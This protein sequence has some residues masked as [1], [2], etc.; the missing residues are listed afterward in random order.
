MRYTYTEEE[1]KIAVSSSF[2]IR[3]VLIKLGVVPAGG[4]YY[5]TNKRILELG[6]DTSHFKNQGWSKGVKIGPKKNIECYLCENSKIT[7]HKLKNR[8]L[9][10]KI[11]EHKCMNCGLIIWMDNLIPLELHHVDGNSKNNKI[12]NLQLLCPNCHSLTDN[13]RGKKIKIQQ[14]QDGTYIR[15]GKVY[16]KTIYLCPCGKP[17]RKDSTICK[18]CCNTCRNTKIVWPDKDKLIQMVQTSSYLAVARK[19][20]V[21]DNAVR[22]RILTH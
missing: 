7:T 10:E 21:S 4:N 5:T 11:F 15:A 8:L 20:G 12:E 3:Q 16:K 18:H 14:K 6:I 9:K 22:K 2:S 17:K 1:L 13:Y 19:L